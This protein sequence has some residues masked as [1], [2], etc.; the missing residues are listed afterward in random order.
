MTDAT[1]PP[2]AIRIAPCESV[3]ECHACED[4]QTAIWGGGEREI[5]PYDILRAIGHAGGTVLGAWHGGEN[6]GR[7]PRFV[8]WGA[9][10]GDHHSPPPGVLPPHPR[11]GGR[12]GPQMT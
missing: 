11:R 5:I 8:A 3:A 10:G 2:P 6:V 12:R 7:A 1:G 4:L 9:G